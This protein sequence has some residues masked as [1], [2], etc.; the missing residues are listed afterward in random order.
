M[1]QTIKCK[2]C[3]KQ[4]KVY[5]HTVADQSACPE[6]IRRAEMMR[7]AKPTIQQMEGMRALSEDEIKEL[8]IRNAEGMRNSAYFY[9]V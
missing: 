7:P 9:D 8:Q 1:E 3:G 2:I 5:S 6:C 4:Y